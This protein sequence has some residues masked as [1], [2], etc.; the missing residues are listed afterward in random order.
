LD[1]CGQHFPT[2]TLGDEDLGFVGKIEALTGQATYL[3]SAELATLL[4]GVKGLRSVNLAGCA[5]DEG[6]LKALQ[7]LPGI[8]EIRLG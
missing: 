7:A 6:V 4:S 8:E 1:L 2:D 5:V 3:D